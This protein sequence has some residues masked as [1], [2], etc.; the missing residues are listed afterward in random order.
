MTDEF[1]K[2]PPKPDEK[3]FWA[4]IDKEAPD[5]LAAGKWF[6]AIDAFKHAYEVRSQPFGTREWMRLDQACRTAKYFDD[7]VCCAQQAL[8]AE[9]LQAANGHRNVDM[10]VVT[11]LLWAYAQ[12][13]QG[14]KAR[15][16]AEGHC[17]ERPEYADYWETKYFREH[18]GFRT[19]EVSCKL[20]PDD[21]WTVVG[22]A[23]MRGTHSVHIPVE[24]YWQKTK[25][26]T[27]TNGRLVEDAFDRVG[28]RRWV[29]RPDDPQ[30]PLD[31]AL[32]LRFLPIDLD[33][34]DVDRV[35]YAR[36]E[37]YE[38]YRGVS[39]TPP[40]AGKHD[41]GLAFIDPTTPLANA[42]AA[43]L[44]GKTRQESLDNVMRWSTFRDNSRGKPPYP[45]SESE[46]EG[47]DGACAGAADGMCA[48]LR[49]Q[50][51]A[52]RPVSGLSCWGSGEKPMGHAQVEVWEPAY[53]RW[54]MLQPDF[55]AGAFAAT[56]YLTMVREQSPG[57]GSIWPGGGLWW[58]TDYTDYRLLAT[59]Q[60]GFF[61]VSIDRL[62]PECVKL[63]EASLTDDKGDNW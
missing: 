58:P 16:L 48:I 57:D 24:T 35:P 38:C 49:A 45:S 44:R 30:K 29:F 63:L 7:A 42:Y 61:R 22:V 19:Y 18:Q 40:P 39:M 37:E 46:P 55:R 25:P 60:Y 59:H 10:K 50:G 15:A 43:L 12:A 52:A 8:A 33:L 62:G 36:P 34:S 47:Y 13:G 2:V 3:A 5:L 26:G 6:E 56:A 51:F 4:L 21:T 41:G 20:L 27:V 1:L 11:R 9:E 23:P 53:D 28:N 17:R 31:L 32:R 14:D 54:I